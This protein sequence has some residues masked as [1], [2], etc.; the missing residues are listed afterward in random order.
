MVECQCCYTDAPAN[1]TVPC[2]GEELHF[3]CFSCIRMSAE[4]QVG[5]MKHEMQCFDTGG[6]KAG[7]ARPVLR[8]ALGA[9]L[10]DKLESLQQQDE[11]TQAGLDGLEGC[12]FCEFK[13]ICQPVEENREFRCANPDCEMISCRLC[14]DET[15]IPKTCQEAKREKGVSERHLV[16]EAMSGALIRTCPTCGVKL[17]KEVGCNKMRCSNC[18]CLMCYTCKKDIT[19]EGYHH[20]ETRR[21]A[22]GCQVYDDNPTLEAQKVTQAE[23]TAIEQI[24]AENPNFSQE[25]LRINRPTDNARP[26]VE[27]RRPRP[28]RPPAPPPR[29]MPGNQALPPIRNLGNFPRAPP[30]MANNDAQVLNMLRHR[31][32]APYAANPP[33]MIRAPPPALSRFEGLHPPRPLPQPQGTPPMNI[34]NAANPPIAR[35]PRAPAP[36]PPAAAPARARAPV[37]APIPYDINRPPQLDINGLPNLYRHGAAPNRHP[38]TH[39]FSEPRRVF[40]ANG[41]PVLPPLYG[42]QMQ[43]RGR[44]VVV[45]LTGGVERQIQREPDVGS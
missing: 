41:P 6:C 43:P 44:G 27:I 21:S 23:K 11:I 8:E 25:D 3:F 38:R 16:E 14:K 15:H 20:F 36:S 31:A 5:L 13:A 26:R 1:R 32:G 40:N 9:S 28:Y 34:P 19:K 37:P 33:N 30:N 17:I 45:D 18:K 22:R 29:L 24:R 12:P 35:V 10:M 4:T 7:F 2:E 42:M 39:T